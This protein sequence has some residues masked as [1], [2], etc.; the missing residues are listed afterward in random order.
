MEAVHLHDHEHDHEHEHDDHD[1]SD[2][3][4]QAWLRAALLFGLGLYFVYNI[5]SGNLSNYVNVRFA[6]LSYVAAAM[7]LLLGL[8]HAYALLPKEKRKRK[9]DEPADHDHDHPQLS[10]RAL[11]VVAIPLV[12]GTLIP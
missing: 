9:N 6:W 11:G 5:V 8:S 1:H 3:H 4:L 7:F 12:L 2:S 10:W